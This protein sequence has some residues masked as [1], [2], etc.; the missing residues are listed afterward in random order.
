MLKKCI[1]IIVLLLIMVVFNVLIFCDVVNIQEKKIAEI[2]NMSNSIEKVENS[3]DLGQV[4]KKISKEYTDGLNQNKN[5]EKETTDTKS[6]WRIEIPKINLEAPIIEGTTQECLSMAVGH[7]EDTDAWKG[8]VALAGHNRGYTNF[9]QNIKK[10]EKGDIIIY[11]TNNGK[12][13]YKVVV[14]TIIKENDWSYIENTEDNRITLITCV[15]NKREY[16]RC[17]QGIEIKNNL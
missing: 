12:R 13:K 7:F 5:I 4:Y 8:N 17:I 10:L 16:R 11:Y 9:F 3:I 15:E 14:N 2:I 6:K 1:N